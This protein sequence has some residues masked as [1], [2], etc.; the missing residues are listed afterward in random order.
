MVVRCSA[1]GARHTSGQTAVY[2]SI[3]RYDPFLQTDPPIHPPTHHGTTAAAEISMGFYHGFGLVK[4]NVELINTKLVWV[5]H[6]L[7]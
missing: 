1:R 2:I 7:N 6:T 4:K 5:F 3:D